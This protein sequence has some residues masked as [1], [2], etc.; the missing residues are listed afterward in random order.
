M[1]TINIPSLE[2]CALMSWYF[3]LFSPN[4][5]LLNSNNVKL[6]NTELNQT[7]TSKQHADF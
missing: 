1:V 4:L 6:N 2:L 7:D 3:S 5:H